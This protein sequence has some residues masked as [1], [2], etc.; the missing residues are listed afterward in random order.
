MDNRSASTHA[1]LV[2]ANEWLAYRPYME[3]SP[4]VTLSMLDGFVDQLMAQGFR[5]EIC[6]S[7]CFRAQWLALVMQAGFLPI[8]MSVDAPRRD[9]VLGPKLHLMRC[10]MDPRA[11]H[12]A[13]TVRKR[14]R[15]F[16]LSV[17]RCFDRVVESIVAQHGEN[18]LFPIVQRALRGLHTPARGGAAS[19]D[20]ATEAASAPPSPATPTATVH[21]FEMWSE[22]PAPAPA[23]DSGSASAFGEAWREAGG[24]GPPQR[25]VA[26]ELGYVVGGVYTSLT[27]FSLR[28]AGAASAG[29]VQL[30]ATARLL[31]ANGFALWDLGMGMAYKTDLG[32]ADV[33]RADFICALRKHRGAPQ[34]A[35]GASRAAADGDAPLPLRRLA[36]PDGAAF[37]N[38]ADIV[39]WDKCVAVRLAAMRAKPHAKARAKARAQAPAAPKASR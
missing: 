15:K 16:T 21:S 18:W 34:R 12:T 10:V 13:K 24:A 23:S 8:A 14:A 4:R 22:A 36:L 27:G 7:E 31:D 20:S 9:V 35:K 39:R 32:A 3:Y 5:G 37:A 25:L 19:C 33:P 38:C 17:D 1:E 11:V 2:A 29:A 28:D 26:G 30:L 6:W